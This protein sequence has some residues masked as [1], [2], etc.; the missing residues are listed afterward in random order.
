MRFSFRLFGLLVFSLFVCSC[1][2]DPFL[3]NERKIDRYDL[4]TAVIP[5]SNRAMVTFRSQGHTLY[6]FYTIP[7]D[8]HDTGYTVLYC[9]GNKHHIGE[10]WPRVE[11]FYKMGLRCFIFD[12]QGFG[13]SEGTPSGSALYSDGRAALDYVVST[14]HV[15]TTKLF[16]YGYSLGNVVSIDL[17][18]ASNHTY[19]VC[20]IAESPFAN[21]EALFHTATPLDLPGSFVI[22]DPLDNASRVRAIHTR[23]LLIHGDA[24]DFVPW[25][26]N[27]RVVFDNAPQPKM[28]ELIHGAKH[29]DI[30]HV[31][32]EAAYM[33]SIMNFIT[34]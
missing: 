16:Y 20:L 5:E 11:L 25:P 21:A 3:Y 1:S 28:L 29:D 17:A 19:P 26:T 14:L 33:D 30:P 9:H 34:R 12:Y 27:G 23:L 6:G 13:R 7:P 22:D 15:D 18:A 24:D 2:L 4:S 10:Y 8:T 31:M 32:G